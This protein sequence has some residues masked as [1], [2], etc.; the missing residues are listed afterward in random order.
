MTSAG[1]RVSDSVR[2]NHVTESVNRRNVTSATSLRGTGQTGY[3][4]SIDELLGLN[5]TQGRPPVPVPRR[6]PEVGSPASFHKNSNASSN[7][8]ERPATRHGSRSSG[9]NATS[10]SSSK[11]ESENVQNAMSSKIRSRPGTTQNSLSPI[12][13][14]SL[15]VWSRDD[16]DV[17]EDDKNTPDH[18]K[19]G[20]S[21]SS[22]SG[23]ESEDSG[24]TSGEEREEDDFAKKLQSLANRTLQVRNNILAQ[25]NAFGKQPAANAFGAL[26]KKPSII[27]EQKSGEESPLQDNKSKTS[28]SQR[29][30]F[31]SESSS[32]QSKSSKENDH[33]L[34]NFT[35]QSRNN[36]KEMTKSQPIHESRRQ[37]RAAAKDSISKVNA[38]N[39]HQ[40]PG[41]K[42]GDSIQKVES[43]A[44]KS[45]AAR[46]N[47]AVR[48]LSV[49]KARSASTNREVEKP[50]G[51][52][53][54]GNK[55]PAGKP[56]RPFST[57]VA[58]LAGFPSQFEK[59]DPGRTNSGSYQ[60]WLKQ[61]LEEDRQKREALKQKQ[62]ELERKKEEKKRDAAKSFERWK[63]ERDRQSAEERVKAR[64]KKEQQE[65]AERL[66]KE[67]KKKHAEK[68]FE[69]WQ[70]S[71]MEQLRRQ[72]SQSS[73]QAKKKVEKETEEQ[74]QKREDAER[75]F[76]EW[77][78]QSN[79]RKSEQE[80][81]SH[82]KQKRLEEQ[83]KKEKEYKDQLAQE[84]YQ[85]WLEMKKQE[86]NFS[87]SLAYKIVEYETESKKRWPS[88][89]WLPTGN[90]APRK[91]VGTGHRRKTLDKPLVLKF[92][93]RT[94]S[95]H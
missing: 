32:A 9:S 43:N 16:E 33:G 22:D 28:G 14:T 62:E 95:V 72:K 55:P 36:P 69:Y 11:R 26:A 31:S 54:A 35:V 51:R 49:P 42:F 21:E 89:P 10:S 8:Q 74:K 23:E 30:S 41:E 15:N 29:S 34:S 27:M 5:A 39:G 66:A 3:S 60:A 17:D 48:R 80:L 53:V 78:K 52:Y 50:S 75:A 64:R 57:T 68:T 85:L 63:E 37:S 20:D 76:Q 84:A 90:T 45:K 40:K 79:R 81:K 59:G 13:S 6:L 87:H 70:K 7:S 83:K 92:S 73:L 4:Q 24:Q 38:V 94:Q 1:E 46:V 58:S 25:S 67:E 71:Q 19:P 82:E 18:I 56:A 2:E 65:E 88:T 86:Q 91:F 47:S 12:A 44:G 93:K 61:K 77:L